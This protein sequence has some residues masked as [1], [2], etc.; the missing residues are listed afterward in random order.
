GP[1]FGTGVDP[2]PRAGP[3]KCVDRRLVA[4]D[5]VR[6]LKPPARKTPPPQPSYEGRTTAHDVPDQAGAV[7]LDHQHHRPL[8]DAEVVRG[9]PPAGR[10]VVHRK[11]LVE[12]RLEPGGGGH[13]QVV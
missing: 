13:T 4:P 11:R 5:R 2:S 3:D 9:D 12:R 7:V 8:I 10:A 1:D 6:V